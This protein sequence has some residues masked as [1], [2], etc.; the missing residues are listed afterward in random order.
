MIKQRRTNMY[1][2]HEIP[3]NK[4]TFCN[5][6]ELRDPFTAT[7]PK[8]PNGIPYQVL[9]QKTPCKEFEPKTKEK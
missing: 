6:C 5:K 9:T 2:I 1:D 8:H 4:V 7:C 3:K